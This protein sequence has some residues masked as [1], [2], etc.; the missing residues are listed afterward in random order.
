MKMLVQPGIRL[1]GYCYN[2]QST[3]KGTNKKLI[4]KFEAINNYSHFQIL[5]SGYSNSVN[6]F[7]LSYIFPCYASASSWA[8]LRLSHILFAPFSHSDGACSSSGYLWDFPLTDAPR[9]CKR[10]GA[11]D[12][13]I[14]MGPTYIIF[15]FFCH[16]SCWER[17]EIRE[18]V[19]P[20]LNDSL[21]DMQQ[22]EEAIWFKSRQN[23]SWT[24]GCRKKNWK[25]LARSMVAE[26]R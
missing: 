15:P 25:W 7:C 12:S 1:S 23:K 22:M 19:S 24:R 11:G 2:F 21:T 4:A 20:L 14:W 6:F 8:C 3:T 26:M 16:C 13:S 17:T 10:R 9:R 5:F 18:P